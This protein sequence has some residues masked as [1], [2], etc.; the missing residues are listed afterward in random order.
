M[1]KLEELKSYVADLF[2]NATE[3]T[4]IDQLSRIQELTTGVEAE[5]KAMVD[6][7]AELIKDYKDLVQHTSFSGDNAPTDQVSAQAPSLEDVLRQ[8]IH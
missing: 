6:K 5:H 1:N 8:F 2:N 4:Q 3:K 7:N